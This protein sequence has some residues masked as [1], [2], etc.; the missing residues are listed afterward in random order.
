[1]HIGSSLALFWGAILLGYAARRARFVTLTF[2]PQMTRWLATWVAPP[3]ALLAM[4][5]NEFTRLPV[6]SL[7]FIGLAVS[8]ASLAPAWWLMRRWRL[9][10][11]RAGSWLLSAFFSNVGFLGALVAFAV[12][13][14][15]AYG[16]CTLYFLFF[17]LGVYTV[18]YGIGDRYGASVPV[19]SPG[20][21]QLE[22]WRWTPMV[23]TLAGVALSWRGVPRPVVLTAINHA[24]IPLMTAAYLFIVGT[25][26]HMSRVGR[27]WREGLWMSAI[28][29]VYAPLVGAAL[30]AWWGYRHLPDPLVWRVVLL[31]SAMPTAIT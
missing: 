18:G 1:M 19:E 31:E 14:E 12:W 7:P 30:G 6:I 2:A 22:L 17:G 16:L 10:K 3:V 24:L 29:L 28:M 5:A 11:P 26:M 21:R 15:R 23:G 13:G 9:S 25:T 20:A 8:C 27:F 4:W